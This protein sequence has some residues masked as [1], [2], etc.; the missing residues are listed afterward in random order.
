MHL[1]PWTRD[2]PPTHGRSLLPVC[3]HRWL[4]EADF[5][6][7]LYNPPAQTSDVLRLSNPGVGDGRASERWFIGGV[8]MC[9]NTIT[10]PNSNN[11]KPRQKFIQTH[12]TN[13]SAR[14]QFAIPPLIRTEW[15]MGVIQ[16]N[17][18][19]PGDLSGHSI[20]CFIVWVT[21]DQQTVRLVHLNLRIEFWYHWMAIILS[22]WYIVHLVTPS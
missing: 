10:K 1:V 6:L 22:R 2:N 9:V 14:M 12:L 16:D 3:W 5:Y 19:R 11:Q 8:S 21:R 7:S 15:E 4:W 13:L 18:G 17:N 20:V